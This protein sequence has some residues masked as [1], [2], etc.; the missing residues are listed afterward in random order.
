MDMLLAHLIEE[1]RQLRREAARLKAEAKAARQRSR[2]ALTAARE[3]LRCSGRCE[4]TGTS[5][6]KARGDDVGVIA[7]AKVRRIAR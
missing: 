5:H 2:A 4:I 3:M 6:Q 1:S 7:L